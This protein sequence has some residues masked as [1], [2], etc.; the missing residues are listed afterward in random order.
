[1]IKYGTFNEVAELQINRDGDIREI[2]RALVLKDGIL[3]NK[4]TINLD[5]NKRP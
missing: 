5:E 3:A 2:G 1:L 4:P